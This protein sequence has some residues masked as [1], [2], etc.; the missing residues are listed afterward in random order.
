MYL[1]FSIIIVSLALIIFVCYHLNNKVVDYQESCIKPQNKFTEQ[2][3]INE[4]ADASVAKKSC[5][6]CRRTRVR[7][8]THESQNNAK[9]RDKRI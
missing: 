8:P 7:K 1:F 9:L 2:V 6:T 3:I 4:T 5:T